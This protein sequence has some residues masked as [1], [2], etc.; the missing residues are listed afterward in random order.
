[1]LSRNPFDI[2]TV[3]ET[4]LKDIKLVNSLLSPIIILN[5][6]TEK[7]GGGVGI[8]ISMK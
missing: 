6:R 1:M 7:R 4:W 2:I 8:Y 5:N 3:S